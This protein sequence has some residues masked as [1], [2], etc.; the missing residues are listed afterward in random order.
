MT[1]T[2]NWP[3]YPTGAKDSIFA[4]GVISS[5]YAQLEFAVY[6]IFTTLLGLESEVSSS[7]M[8]KT[9]PE[10]RDKLMR[11]VLPTRNW[12]E[13]VKDLVQHF[14]EAHK[15]C[16][17]NRNKVAHSNLHSLSPDAIILAKVSREGRT[18]LARISHR[19]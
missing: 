11:E 15:I 4:L 2:S 16:Y 13:N 6:A 9:S 5:N 1:D 3:K 19:K 14:I 18:T 12:P 17:E 8:Y 7:L 10:M